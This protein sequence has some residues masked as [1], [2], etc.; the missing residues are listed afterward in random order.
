MTARLVLCFDGTW[1]KP[2][3][4]ASAGGAGRD[5]RAPLPRGGDGRGADGTHQIKWYSAGVG[6]RWDEQLRGGAFGYGID[7]IIRN[8]YEFL[9]TQPCR[10]RRDLRARLQPQRLCGPQPGRHAPQRP[11]LVNDL[12]FVVCRLRAL[13]RSR[14]HARLPQGD[15]VTRCDA[16]ARAVR[17]KFLGVWDTVGALGIPRQRLRYPSRSPAYAGLRRGSISFT[18]PASPGSSRTPLSCR[19][20]RR[21]IA[22]NSSRRCGP[23]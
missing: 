1:N 23:P 7:E 19:R 4:G 2:D 13:P 3:E 8:G 14:R 21:S 20:H 6:T 5:Q 12:D 11:G 22:R 9:V 10:R 15:R 17:V 18:I 16:N